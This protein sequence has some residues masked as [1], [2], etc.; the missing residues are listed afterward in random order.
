MFLYPLFLIDLIITWTGMEYGSNIFIKHH[1]FS[2]ETLNPETISPYHPWH[3][4]FYLSLYTIKISLYSLSV[5]V[6]VA[7]SMVT[8]HYQRFVY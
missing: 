6:R 4:I 3:G 1:C 8:S 2:I 7:V 5:M